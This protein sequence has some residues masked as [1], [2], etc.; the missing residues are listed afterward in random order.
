MTRAPSTITP[1]SYVNY[2]GVTY[3]VMA[4]H[5]GKAYLTLGQSP[6]Q[7]YVPLGLTQGILYANHATVRVGHPLLYKL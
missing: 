2:C 5:N 3:R 7:A 6:Y 1:N 4:V